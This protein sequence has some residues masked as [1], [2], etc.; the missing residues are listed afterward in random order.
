MA[1]GWI[2]NVGEFFGS[3]GVSFIKHRARTK[4][5]R[6]GRIGS[7]TADADI[8]VYNAVN[9]GLKTCIPLDDQVNR[10]GLRQ[11]CSALKRK[12]HFGAQLTI[13]ANPRL[14]KREICIHL[15]KYAVIYLCSEN[16]ADIIRGATYTMIVCK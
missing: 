12:D 11:L 7:S 1:I 3:F 6:I 2:G 10:R 13:D 5:R 16:P 4:Q 14:H 15:L 8:A 9:E